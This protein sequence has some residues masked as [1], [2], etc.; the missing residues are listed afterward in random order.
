MSGDLDSKSS[1]PGDCSLPC[2]G[3]RWGSPRIPLQ[4]SHCLPYWAALRTEWDHGNESALETLKKWE[5]SSLSSSLTARGGMAE[6]V[7]LPV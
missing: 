7:F 4:G 3:L 1:L 6:L 5:D 2:P